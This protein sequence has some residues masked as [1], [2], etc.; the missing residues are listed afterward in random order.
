MVVLYS[1]VVALKT[2][3]RRDPINCIITIHRNPSGLS[4]TIEPGSVVVVEFDL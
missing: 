1:I 4:S 2:S 3:I